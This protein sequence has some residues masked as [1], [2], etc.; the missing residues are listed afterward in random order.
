MM[1]KIS[2]ITASAGAILL[3]ARD[4]RTTLVV[5]PIQQQVLG[6]AIASLLNSW[7]LEELVESMTSEFVSCC[8]HEI[9]MPN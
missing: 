2:T 3:A 6:M 4:L 9:A 5:G 7:A 1:P 8:D